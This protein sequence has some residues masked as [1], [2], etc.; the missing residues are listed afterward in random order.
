MKKAY[1]YDSKG[2]LMGEIEMQKDP[3]ESKIQG[4]TVYLVPAR[5]TL[6]APPKAKEGELVKWN[7]SNWEV[8]PE[9]KKPEEP[10]PEEPTPEEL[11]REATYKKAVSNL[12]KVDAGKLTLEEMRLVIKDILTLMVPTE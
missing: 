12:Q 4:K 9:P 7:G 11:E 10:K 6:E 8:L 5:A 1:T 2:L 3:L